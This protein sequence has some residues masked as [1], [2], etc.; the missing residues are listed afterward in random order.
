M[1]LRAVDPSFVSNVSAV[2]ETFIIEG[3][4]QSPILIARIVVDD[5]NDAID[6]NDGISGKMW[7]ATS[8]TVSSVQTVWQRVAGCRRDLSQAWL[9]GLRELRALLSSFSFQ[10]Q[11]LVKSCLRMVGDLRDN[12]AQPGMRVDVV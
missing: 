5:L 8:K 4:R 3:G 7:I 11:K 12:I 2:I 9:S 1:V 6:L 10:R